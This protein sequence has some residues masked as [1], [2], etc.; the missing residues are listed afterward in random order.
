M[1]PTYRH[2]KLRKDWGKFPGNADRKILQGPER[3][4]V[5]MWHWHTSLTVCTLWYQWGMML[6]LG[7]GTSACPRIVVW[8][9]GQIPGWRYFVST[10]PFP[11][12]IWTGSDGY[13]I[14]YPIQTVFTQICF[15]KFRVQSGSCKCCLQSRIIND[16]SHRKSPHYMYFFYHPTQTLP[17]D[18]KHCLSYLR[19]E[20]FNF[21]SRI[22][23]QQVGN[24]FN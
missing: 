15:Q 24:I 7:Y 10:L 9:Q 5:R 20:S 3:R 1:L 2:G 22:T 16:A 11:C 23:L 13:T 8:L 19:D 18:K 17:E 12:L 14:P 6:L 21:L 4:N